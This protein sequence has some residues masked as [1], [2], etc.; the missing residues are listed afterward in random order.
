MKKPTAL[1]TSASA[2]L[3]HTLLA[4]GL[5]PSLQQRL[6]IRTEAEFGAAAGLPRGPVP[7]CRLMP[8]PPC[9]SVPLGFPA[10]SVPAGLYTWPRRGGDGLGLD[11]QG[12]NS[13]TKSLTSPQAMCPSALYH[14]WNGLRASALVD[15]A[16][17]LLQV[18]YVHIYNIYTEE[19]PHNSP[20]CAR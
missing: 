5:L 8:N 2:L 19:L 7:L 10:L 4:L 9:P 11:G 14:Y 3:D 12:L 6:K 1:N 13:G 15:P 17:I 20:L 16:F 18:V